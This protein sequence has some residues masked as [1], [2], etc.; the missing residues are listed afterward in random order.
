MNQTLCHV[1]EKTSSCSREVTATWSRSS[2]VIHHY[3]VVCVTCEPMTT[4]QEQTDQTRVLKVS[5]ILFPDTHSTTWT[6]GCMRRIQQESYPSGWAKQFSGITNHTC[7]SEISKTH[8]YKSLIAAAALTSAFL[9]DSLLLFVSL[10]KW[11]NKMLH[12]RES[13]LHVWRRQR[14]KP[15]RL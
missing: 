9:N 3:S 6:R 1:T 7:N 11:E 15:L 5:F 12:Q 13:K 10:F 8:F 4:E 14:K 2:P